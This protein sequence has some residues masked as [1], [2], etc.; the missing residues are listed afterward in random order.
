MKSLKIEKLV[1]EH[2]EKRFHGLTFSHKELWVIDGKHE[3]FCFCV[4]GGEITADFWT[5]WEIVQFVRNYFGYFQ[6]IKLI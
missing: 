1:I 6:P 5:E 4:S 2:V 3:T